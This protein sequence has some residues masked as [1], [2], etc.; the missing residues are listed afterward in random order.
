MEFQVIRH[1]HPLNRIS[2]ELHGR[3]ADA[4]LIIRNGTDWPA[5]PIS[6]KQPRVMDGPSIVQYIIGVPCCTLLT[7]SGYNSAVGIG[8]PSTAFP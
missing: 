5:T 8:G 6:L 7:S 1:S 4:F 2:D 3:A